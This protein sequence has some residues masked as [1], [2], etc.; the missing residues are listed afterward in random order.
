MLNEKQ[1]NFDSFDEIYK[2]MMENRYK[3]ENTSHDLLNRSV[4]VDDICAVIRRKSAEKDY[5]S[6][7]VSGVWGCGKSFVLSEIKKKLGSEFIFIPY[8]C[9]EN[10]Y[11]DE[12]LYG[13]LY[14][15]A[16]F[17]NKEDN[18]DFAQSQYYK[19]MRR[20]IFG[21]AKNTPLMG[22]I[23]GKIMSLGSGVVKEIQRTKSTEEFDTNL[24]E[25]QKNVHSILDQI[26]AAIA[27]YI[28]FE[29]KRI[30]IAVDELDRCL[31][32]YA[33]KVLNRLHHICYGSSIILITAV[34]KEELLGCINTAYS[35]NSG[36][37]F[38]KKYIDRFFDYT[39]N[40]SK[41]NASELLSLWKNLDCFDEAI[42][43]RSFL[44]DI[45]VSVLKNFSM[46]EKKRLI[47]T[48]FSLHKIIIEEIRC[49]EA[50][51]FAV[52]CAE[53]MFA[54]NFLYF[55]KYNWDF[56]IGP[57][58]FGPFDSDNRDVFGNPKPMENVFT[59][60]LLRKDENSHF[61]SEIALEELISEYDSSVP[62][63]NIPI[64]TDRERLKALF[65]NP[66]APYTNDP[67]CFI[68]NSKDSLFLKE[69]KVFELFKKKLYQSH[70]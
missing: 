3:S 63:F 34:N 25:F 62:H 60:E 41:G 36:D 4:E 40:L 50:L 20:T 15:L 28:T 59:L 23:P 11:Y 65:A 17:F 61:V 16:L 53:L 13:I 67:S 48:T 55:D 21:I 49:E 45:C 29:N 31:P 6:M 42:V 33:L 22:Q 69:K 9:W 52:L 57:F 44:N 8:D 7:A 10:D 68:C 26:T 12:P 1:N 54:V 66:L 64:D 2:K 43:S 46:R 70:C 47:S 5:F 56:A 19:A 58:D 32:N 37:E 14:S 39:Y 27:T 24:E 30:V 35:K 51:S 38:S 18:P